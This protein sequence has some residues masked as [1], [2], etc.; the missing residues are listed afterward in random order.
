[1]SNIPIPALYESF[2]INSELEIAKARVPTL[3]EGKWTDTSNSDPGIVAIRVV[4]ELMARWLYSGSARYVAS[5]VILHLP[6]L[7]GINTGEAT[8]AEGMAQ[9]IVIPNTTIQAGFQVAN[10]VTGDVYE[11][12]V[13]YTSLVGGA[14][15][16][17][18]RALVAGSRANTRNA[19]AITG[20]RSNPTAGQ[21]SA[22]TNITAIDGGRD[23]ETPAE[24]AVRFPSLIQNET[25][26]RPEQ[27]EARALENLSIARAHVFR[28]IRPGAIVGQ[29]STEV[30]HATV[31]CI[32]PGGAAPSPSTLSAVAMSMLADTLWNLSG[33]TADDVGLHV[34]GVRNRSVNVSLTIKATS[35][36]IL[37]NLQTIAQS[38]VS[39]Y[40]QPLTGGQNGT[41]F[42]LGRPPREYEIGA[43]VEE[44]TG[45]E[46]VVDDSV[47]ITGADDMAIDEIVTPGS[48]IVTVVY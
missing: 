38:A 9:F 42:D 28:A 10:D 7:L 19:G 29:F 17:E 32:G 6:K 20:I 22:V 14:I 23:A 35:G 48:V 25:L 18:V 39:A 41:G 26:L 5:D 24:F 1:M 40:L 47:V 11:T 4:L 3:S 2:E 30:D 12:K 16:L 21:V 31:I 8:R 36:A 43:V 15:E 33:A 44:L 13:E 34:L 27:F 46:Y 45:V 37:S